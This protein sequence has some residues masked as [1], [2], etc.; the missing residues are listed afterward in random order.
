[1]RHVG[2]FLTALMACC[3]TIGARDAFSQADE[4]AGA[5][6][7]GSVR[8]VVR[9]ADAGNAPVEGAAINVVGTG[10]QAA[11]G[12][13]GSYEIKGVPA[14]PRQLQI[15]KDG[16][17]PFRQPVTV[18]P[19][20]AAGADFLLVSDQGA[21][22]MTITELRAA[23]RV[24]LE[25][26]QASTL[27]ILQTREDLKTRPKGDVVGAVEELPGV[28]TVDGKYVY[29]RGLGD[30]Y[31]QTLLNNSTIPS[32]EPDK[33]VV[34]L[35]LF[36]TSLVETINIVKTYSPSLPGEFAGGSVQ[37]KTIDVPEA[38]FFTLGADLE[39]RHGTTFR[40]FNTYHGGNLDFLSFDDGTREIPGDVPRDSVDSPGLTPEDRQAIGRSFPN[41]WEPDS[42]TAPLDHKL[43]L[44]F[45]ER[46]GKE[47]SGLFG[48]VGALNWGNK[49]QRVQDEERRFLAV[50]GNPE[51]PTQDIAFVFSD[52][53]LDTSTFEAELSGALNLAYEFNPGHTVGVRNLYTRSADD[54][55]RLQS[56]REGN[57][58]DDRPIQ[59][60]LLRWVERSLFTTQPFGEH[61][62]FADTCLEWRFTYALSQRDEPDNRQIQYLYDPVI[63]DYRFEVF[64]G[65]GRR[66]FFLLDE[67]IYDGALDYSIP[68]N[69]F[70]VPDKR[71]DPDRKV[72]EQR[73]KLGPAGLLR[74]RDFEGRR[75]RFRPA[76]GGIPIDENGQP[77][78]LTQSPEDLFQPDNI[79]PNGW[80]LVEDTRRTDAY[81]ATQYILAGYALADFR[82]H[83]DWRVEGGARLEWSKQTI[84][85]F[86]EG[87][88][89]PERERTI[90]ETTD[91]LPALNLI[92][93]FLRDM[94][95]RVAGSGTVSR[96]EFRELAPF[97]YTDVAG[98]FTAEGNPDLDRAKIWNADLGWEWFPG[99]GDIVTAGLFYKHFIDPIEV[100]NVPT[101]SGLITSWDNADTADLFGIELETRKN[102]AFLHGDLK[103]L[104]LLFNYTWMWSEVRIPADPS[105]PQTNDKRPLQG[106]PE[107][108][109]NAGLLYDAKTLGLTVGIFANMIG[110][111][112]TAVGT[113]GLDDEVE[114]P[115][116][117]LDLSVTK[118]VGKGT[119]KFTV[120]NIL[121]DNYLWKQS[122]FTTREF[123]KGLSV[124]IGYSYSF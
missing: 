65:S 123:R 15:I 23:A 104:S 76:G 42:S 33:R 110:D 57:H 77:V 81:Q 50:T 97:Q 24:P 98:G 51:D 2:S 10:L 112:I 78:D 107:F 73:I 119:I 71:P 55:V 100:V 61:L 12:A 90:L 48:I 99:G 41:I 45:G 59:V 109:F 43:S 101:S 49:Y 70:G 66:D 19:G 17:L 105:N 108:V 86:E 62:L 72:P 11:T 67:N 54:T 118:Q 52:F 38:R 14:G 37:I 124:G 32:P 113:S 28:S 27:G 46:L 13:D 120:E 80:V 8:G 22:T 16:F 20:E 21:K 69:P 88:A 93:E 94:Q 121:N 18:R 53:T 106:M 74:D 85:S 4:P 56:G 83:P 26:K 47:G 29:V 3:L 75:F 44:S 7:P 40:D 96:P 1:M 103:D 63:D 116:W 115:R 6:A 39:Y 91:V 79:N 114:K 89:V 60:T 102:L 111:R 9:N 36:P 64:F 87:P 58:P 5:A 92:W 35:D 68:F 122:G 82:L 31:S 30:R 95:L 34:P 25:R 84:S 117:N